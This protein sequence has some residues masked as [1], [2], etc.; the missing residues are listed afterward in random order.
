MSQIFRK[1][2]TENANPKDE[3]TSKRQNS[4]VRNECRSRIKRL[5]RLD[6]DTCGEKVENE[7]LFHEAKGPKARIDGMAAHAGYVL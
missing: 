1:N 2:A 5:Y 6:G 4:T 7:Q 3:P